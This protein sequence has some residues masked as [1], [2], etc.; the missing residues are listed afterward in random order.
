MVCP[1][2]VV[3]E[4]V[5]APYK[6]G[7]QEKYFTPACGVCLRV[8]CSSAQRRRALNRSTVATWGSAGI[9]FGP[10]CGQLRKPVRKDARAFAEGRQ[11]ARYP[12]SG[13]EPR[14]IYGTNPLVNVRTGIHTGS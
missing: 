12:V 9:P 6:R 2:H 14:N 1:N 4:R 7:S 3:L 5:S 10:N 11:T 13:D 8:S